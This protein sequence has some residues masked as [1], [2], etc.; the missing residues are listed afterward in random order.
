MVEVFCAF[1]G[2][3]ARFLSTN[4]KWAEKRS[5][6]IKNDHMHNHHNF[7]LMSRAQ[8]EFPTSEDKPAP[9]VTFKPMEK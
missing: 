5:A 2:L 1:C 3:I 7:G 4:P 8:Y 9:R 6:R